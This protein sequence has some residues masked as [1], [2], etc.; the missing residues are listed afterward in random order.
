MKIG[1]VATRQESKKAKKRIKR[2]L[3]LLI[4]GGDSVISM[5]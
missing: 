2:I 1:P 4:L 5:I 3:T